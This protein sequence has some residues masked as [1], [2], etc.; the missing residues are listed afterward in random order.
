MS[1]S[2][3]ISA[4]T[5]SLRSTF[6]QAWEQTAEPAP[7]APFTTE[8]PS[9]SRIEYYPNW[10]P[11]P[12]ATEWDGANDYGTPSSYIYAIENKLYRTAMMIRSLDAEDD[13]TG[14][15]ARKPEETAEECRLVP[16]LQVMR[17]LAAGATGTFTPT[18][19]VYGKSF[20]GQYFF[21]NRTAGLG[22]GVG[23]NILPTYTTA[24]GSGGDST[25]YNII[26]LYHGQKG[27]MLKPMVW[28]RRGGPKFMTNA[29]TP[30]EDESLQI[31]YWASIRGRAA[32]GI[33]YNAV[34]QKIVGKP[35]LAEMHDM[36]QL[37]EA[38]FRTFQ[39]PL[40]RSTTFGHYVHEQTKFGTDNFTLAGSTGIAEQLRAALNQDWA[41]VNIG[42]SGATNTAPTTNDF[43]GFANYL[44]SNYLNGAIS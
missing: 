8:L 9:T 10:S 13:Q 3:Q 23:N 4:L 21:A 19:E 2:T 27:K 39:L 14:A 25:V 38:Q 7:S 16:Y 18:N 33:W 31:R 5:A 17:A 1:V 42:V 35:N 15:L 22:F 37:I 40:Y 30:Q 26:A 36:F 34:L 43:K 29:G 20:D 24:A 28:Q 12:A 6:W 32:Y 44:V 11:V 41:P